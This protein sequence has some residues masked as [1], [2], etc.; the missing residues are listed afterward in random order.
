MIMKL[1]STH[2]YAFYTLSYQC[3]SCSDSEKL[4]VKASSIFKFGR[5]LH[6]LSLTAAKYSLDIVSYIMGKSGIL[7]G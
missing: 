5:V 4:K 2:K 6:A 3:L 1:Q 7:V